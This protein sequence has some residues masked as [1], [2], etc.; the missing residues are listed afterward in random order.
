VSAIGQD[1]DGVIRQIGVGGEVVWERSIY[2]L[3]HIIR[4]FA[5]EIKPTWRDRLI[6]NRDSCNHVK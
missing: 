1:V 3:K 5:N 2:I 4:N 6:L